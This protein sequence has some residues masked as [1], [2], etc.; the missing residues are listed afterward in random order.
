MDEERHDKTIDEQ[1]LPPAGNSN[2]RLYPPV[3][4]SGSPD[5]GDAATREDD[6][7]Q[8]G[9]GDAA[10]RREGGDQAAQNL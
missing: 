6:A 8:P 4:E 7:D 3:E 5:E 2:A 1:E 10:A 9:H